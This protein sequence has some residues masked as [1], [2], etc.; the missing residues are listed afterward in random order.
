MQMVAVRVATGEA[1]GNE[2][3]SDIR[4]DEIGEEMTEDAGE[5]G[6]EPD[7]H[8]GDGGVIQGL[9][10][11]DLEG[12]RDQGSGLDAWD[13]PKDLEASSSAINRR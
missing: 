2:M 11:M 13:A 4:G 3:V 8:L 5:T 12:I 1:I 7:D 9:K 10:E 6:S